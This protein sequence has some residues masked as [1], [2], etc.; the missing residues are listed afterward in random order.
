M[1][2]QKAAARTWCAESGDRGNSPRLFAFEKQTKEERRTG[3]LNAQAYPDGGLPRYTDEEKRDT[4]AT[5][6]SDSNVYDSVPY[7]SLAFVQTHPDRLAV[8]ATLFGLQPTPVEHCRV[9][10][11][12]CGNGS[13]LIPMAYGL[14]RSQFVGVDLAA[15]PVQ[16]AQ[17][18]ISRLELK[19]IRIQAMD[20]MEIEPD[21]GKFDYIIAHGVFAWVPEHV[22]QKILSIC[23][24]N[25]S[26]NGVA[27]VSYNTNPAGHVRQT[28][29]E[30]VQ[31]H[32]GRTGRPTEGSG[33]RVKMVRDFLQAIL[34]ATDA[35][36]PWKA[37]LQEELKL[38]FSRD[39]NVVYHD[40]LAEYFLPVSFAKFASRAGRCGLQFLSEAQITDVLAP[41]LSEE[42]LEALNRMAEG[43]VIALQQYLDFARYRKFRQ[44]LLCHAE[45]PLRR[46]G[47]L[48]RL[49]GLLVASPMKKSAD[50][51]DGSVEFINSRGAGTIETNNPAIIAI[52]RRLEE[53]WPHGARFKDLVSTSLP[54]VQEAQ[55][56]EAVGS[57]AQV[58]L[59]L[60]ASMLAD[61][62]TYRLP[63]PDGIGEKPTASL[64]A[65]LIVEEGRMVT[66]LLHTHV[67]IEDEQGRKFLQLLDGTRDRQAL[68][69]ALAGDLPHSSP[70]TILKQVDGN[71]INFHQMGL[72]VG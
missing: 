39:E 1:V 9:L 44:T 28:L 41:E 42:G 20:L 69:A 70:E 51:P 72:L 2:Q 6:S 33:D 29:R 56:G 7:P 5:M 4:V 32:E 11:L 48:E 55:R 21:F 14:P 66:T 18:R 71:L 25:L 57:L 40:D 23:S 35:K 8:M 10:E 45:A 27:F 12:G 13:N 65:R 63:F 19:N 64:L 36:T 34:K 62:R 16:I 68:A 46:D 3:L 22:Q 67:N 37:L 17:G 38:T 59:K 61:V 58:V 60:A 30:M 31:F 26:A 24:A 49:A 52:L 43:D 50:K 47:V 15:K 54:L 53:I